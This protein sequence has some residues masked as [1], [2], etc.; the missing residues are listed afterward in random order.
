MGSLVII[1]FIFYSEVFCY[2][3]AIELC[4][5]SLCLLVAVSDHF[6]G[7]QLMIDEL[8]DEFMVYSLFCIPQILI[9]LLHG[10]PLI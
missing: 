8:F 10:F 3:R 7:Y 6:L 9:G 4:L 2:F 5:S 1:G